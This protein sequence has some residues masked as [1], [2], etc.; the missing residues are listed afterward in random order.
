MTQA[1]M[2]SSLAAELLFSG[3]L[4]DLSDHIRTNDWH[5]IAVGAMI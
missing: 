1:I 2:L 5:V 4:L 3:D